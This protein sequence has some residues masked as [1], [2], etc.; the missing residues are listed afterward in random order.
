MLLSLSCVQI[1]KALV[2]QV[3]TL[4]LTSRAFY[5]GKCEHMQEHSPSDQEQQLLSTC[6]RCCTHDLI[7]LNQA[8]PLHCTDTLG[9]YEEFITRMFGYDKVLPMNTGVEAGETAI[10]LARWVVCDHC[11]VLGCCICTNAQYRRKLAR[12]SASQEMGLR[13]E[14]RAPQPGQG[15][16]RC[17]QLLG[18]HHICYLIFD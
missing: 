9:D 14:G 4:A 2:D 3:S 15:P 10:K 5:N 8:H 1:L 13:C 17:W 6:K 7:S 16:V 11:C 12:C 18:A